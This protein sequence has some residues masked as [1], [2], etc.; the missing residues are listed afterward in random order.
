MDRTS[1]IG[2]AA[3]RRSHAGKAQD[4]DWALSLVL[5]LPTARPGTLGMSV[6]W[7]P[8]VFRGYN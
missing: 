8:Y 2:F 6:L 3:W 5:D 4:C 7:L 1:R